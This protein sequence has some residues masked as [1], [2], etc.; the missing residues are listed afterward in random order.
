M[1]K[2]A[3]Q[4]SGELCWQLHPEQLQLAPAAAGLVRALT[5]IPIEAEDHSL[6][7]PLVS[8]TPIGW[9]HTLM[10]TG[11]IPSKAYMNMGRHA[12]AVDTLLGGGGHGYN[13]Q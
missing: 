3:S 1:M 5:S 4:A 12:S 6:E 7:I 10:P 9:E 11:W 8:G 13:Y 2:G